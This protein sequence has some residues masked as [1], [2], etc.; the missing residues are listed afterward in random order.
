MKRSCRFGLA[1]LLA[2]GWLVVLEPGLAQLRLSAPVIFAPT[3]VSNAISPRS[4]RF[5]LSGAAS[6]QAYCVVFSPALNA[7]AGEWTPFA[8]GAVGQV[9]FDIPLPADAAG[10]F[11]AVALTDYPPASAGPGGLPFR[12]LGNFS[13]E[14]AQ[15]YALTHGPA[16]ASPAAETRS[17]AGVFV[18]ATNGARL[19]VHSDDG[20]TVRINGQDVLGKLGVPTTL[21]NLNSYD[22]LGFAFT[23]GGEYHVEIDY[24]SN[25]HSP[26]DIDGVTLY[27]WNGGGSVRQ[28]PII[29]G[30]TIVCVGE[31]VALSV[32]GGRPSYAWASGNP[33]VA[34]VSGSGVV[35]AVAAG[36]VTVTVT[37][38][39]GRSDSHPVTVLA[40]AV[41]PARFEVCLGATN[42]FSVT[43][44]PCANPVS[45]TP[46]GVVSPDTF[47]NEVKFT[48]PGANIFVTALYC[49]CA[50]RA[51]GVVVAAAGLTASEQWVCAGVPVV[52]TAS[53]TPPG[54]EHLLAWEGEGL[55]GSGAR[56]TNVFVTPGLKTIRVTCGDSSASVSLQVERV[57][58]T[59]RAVTLLAGGAPAAFAMT[60]SMAFPNWRVQP[61]VPGG[62]TA[63]PPSGNGTTVTP[64]NVGTNY[65]LHAFLD[66]PSGVCSDTAA[67]QVV[68]V[69]FATNRVYACD[70]AGARVGVNVEPPE[71]LG[72]IVFDTVTNTAT[73]RGWMPWPACCWRPAARTW[74]C[75][76]S[77]PVTPLCACASANGRCSARKSRSCA[78]PIRPSRGSSR[79]ASFATSGSRSSRRTPRFCTGPPTS[80]SRSAAA[81]A[82]TSPW[83]AGPTASRSSRRNCPPAWSAP[84]RKSPP[85]PSRWACPRSPSAWARRP[86]SPSPSF[87][88]TRK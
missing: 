2:T 29:R 32:E 47:R 4:L 54:Y 17:F 43:N 7:P 62:A 33:A 48:A 66:G 53:T 80:P 35:T 64:G 51:T 79:G 9:T 5:E 59:P 82:P 24:K 38:A 68:S 63:S 58:I 78:W 45:W 21:T 71:F 73:V 28:G 11:R 16:Y 49:G 36:G 10:F 55:N 6:N 31:T 85:W 60:N 12:N 72:A 40:P 69:S 88:R 70:G 87:P 25:E 41:S 65:V 14:Q 52:L 22:E 1:V 83:R 34:A 20:S 81:A 76:R 67:V 56:R 3:V 15:D 26:G 74:R 77:G 30:P 18:P 13:A 23:N 39:D 8:T 19:S 61:S 37:D 86:K 46:A 84:A 44:A 75:P 50:A 27:A 42:S 57:E